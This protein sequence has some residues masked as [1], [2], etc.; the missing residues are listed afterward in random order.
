MTF[1]GSTSAI[2]IGS[3]V[4]CICELQ[5]KQNT[6]HPNTYMYN[7]YTLAISYKHNEMEND[8]L[9]MNTTTDVLKYIILT[10]KKWTVIT[11]SMHYGTLKKCL[12]VVYF[13]N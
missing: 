8:K 4:F 6:R 7:V 13:A 3:S 9:A 1:Y 10:E 5:L 12:E 2:V 11:M